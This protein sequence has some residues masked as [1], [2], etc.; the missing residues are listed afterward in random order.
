[1]GLD[2]WVVEYV[3][4]SAIVN[5]GF[6]NVSHREKPASVF[7]AIR[8]SPAEGVCFDRQTDNRGRLTACNWAYPWNKRVETRKGWVTTQPF[9]LKFGIARYWTQTRKRF[10][11]IWS[12]RGCDPCG[13]TITNHRRLGGWIGWSLQARSSWSLFCREIKLPES[14]SQSAMVFWDASRW[15]PRLYRSAGII[16]SPCLSQQKVFQ[17]RLV[18]RWYIGQSFR[19][20]CWLMR[21][22][23][24]IERQA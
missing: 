12:N 11:V 10:T 4:K 20:H 1:M 14:L 7:W 3:E 8:K 13:V 9:L 15:S 19:S 17:G 5:S 21:C 6:V 24:Q 18:A 22:A 16:G 2:Q 23:V